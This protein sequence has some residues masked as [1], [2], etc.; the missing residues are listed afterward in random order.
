[1]RCQNVVRL[2]GT[3]W[4]EEVTTCS[5]EA[6][7][8]EFMTAWTSVHDISMAMLRL[9]LLDEE[10]SGNKYFKLLPHLAVARKAGVNRLLSFGG[11]WSNHLHAL[12]AAGHRFGFETLGVVRGEAAAKPTACLE[13][14][15]AWGMQLHHVSRQEYRQRNSPHYIQSLQ[16]EFGPCHIIPEGGAS[17]TGIKGCQQIVPPGLADKFT[18]ILLACGTGTTM[19]GL[20]TSTS[21][22]VTGIQVLKGNGYLHQEINH[23][24]LLH[25][26]ETR[27]VH[28]EILD[29]FHRGGFARVD[30][31]LLAFMAGFKA[32]T[33]IPLEPVYS[34]KMLLALK[35]L[36][37][38]G[39]YPPGSRVLVIHGGGLQGNRGLQ[40]G[41]G[42]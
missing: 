32:E 12:A 7:V 14:A 41:S 3:V 5:T 28:W 20:V 2:S 19:C 13:D 36:L 16:K 39:Y 33:G 10:I 8:Q 18:H 9:D 22:P 30:E 27:S 21:L 38:S 23:M 40:R 15:R 11:A 31:A 6:I 35:A 24:L 34:G 17:L 29:G 25:G 26:L 37:G 42:S 1:V 4:L